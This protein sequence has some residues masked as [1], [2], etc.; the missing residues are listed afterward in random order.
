MSRL[1]LVVVTRRMGSRAGLLDVSTLGEST[2]EM[3]AG[4]L[5]FE[6][7][8]VWRMQ[9]RTKGEVPWKR[10]D[11]RGVYYSR[12]GDGVDGDGVKEHNVVA[13]LGEVLV[14]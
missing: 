10:M 8:S 3:S 9:L 11:Y 4:E 13:G 1:P 6:L 2:D 5:E 7:G 14:R 12:F